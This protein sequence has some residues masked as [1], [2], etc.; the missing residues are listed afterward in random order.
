MLKEIATG[1]SEVAQKTDKGIPNFKEGK[2]LNSPKVE[3]SRSKSEE[4]PNFNSTEGVKNR[5][6]QTGGVWEGEPGNSKWIP[7]KDKI[8]QNERTNPEGKT[9]GEI[10]INSD[11]D[12]VEFKDGYPDFSEYAEET[13]EI[14]DF[15][16]RRDDN[17]SQADKKTA[18]K[19][20]SDGKEGGPWTGE[21]VREYRK[22]NKLTWHEHEDTKTMQLVKT[23]VHGN[24]P[25]VGGIA[26][27]KNSA[28]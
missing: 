6:P 22:E 14:D 20:N 17:F 28:A 25:H 13:V 21:K 5:W 4:I 7:D 23:E 16:E 9:W 26:N 3:I 11:T 15:S 18:E 8:P 2:E 27:K 24:I 12:G 1:A 10:F 19:W